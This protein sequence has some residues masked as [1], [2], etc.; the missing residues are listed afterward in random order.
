MYCDANCVDN[1]GVV[2]V[3][4]ISG[5]SIALMAVIVVAVMALD[6]LSK[7]LVLINIRNGESIPVI[8]GLFDLTLTYN[9]GAAFGF[10]AGVEDGLR[11]VLLALTTCLALGAVLYFLI[12]DYSKDPLAQGALAMIVGGAFG[13][14]IDRFRLGAVVDFLDVFYG[15]Y[16]WPAFNLADSFICVGVAVLLFRR[17][18]KDATSLKPA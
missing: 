8:P 9:R 7:A 16:H 12:K 5:R 18:K 14:I 4:R 17:P 2:P 10:L 6:Q 11:H 15:T 13:N 1:G 3:Q